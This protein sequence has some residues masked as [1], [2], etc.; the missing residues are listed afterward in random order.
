M[1]IYDLVLGIRIHLSSLE[2]LGSVFSMD[3]WIKTLIPNIFSWYPW[4]ETITYF[5]GANFFLNFYPQ[6]LLELQLIL[7]RGKRWNR[8]LHAQSRVC[9]E[10][11]LFLRYLCVESTLLDRYLCVLSTLFLKYLCVASTLFPRYLCVESTLS[12]VFMRTCLYCF[13]CI[14]A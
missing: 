4:W 14:Y 9:V 8:T 6:Y 2:S 5:L 7:V 10:S 3:L 11:T 1:F 12:Q 13:H